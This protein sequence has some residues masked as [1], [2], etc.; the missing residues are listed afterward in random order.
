MR[1]AFRESLKAPIR[2]TPFVE[3]GYRAMRFEGQ[4]GLEAVFA[5]M[6]VT[7]IA[8]PREPPLQDPKSYYGT[9]QQIV[10]V[11]S[12]VIFAALGVVAYRTGRLPR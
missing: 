9:S 7:N 1:Q 12:G 3:R 5:V 10:D 6:L 4:I 11:W 8:S 2:L